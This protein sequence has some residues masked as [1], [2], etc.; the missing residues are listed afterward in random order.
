METI[1]EN[2]DVI[3]YFTTN[4]KMLMEKPY[5]KEDIESAFLGNDKTDGYQNFKKKYPLSKRALPEHGLSVANT[6]EREILESEKKDS[7]GES[8]ASIPFLSK[9]ESDSSSSSSSTGLSSVPGLSQIPG[10]SSAMSNTSG[11]SS[12]TPTLVMGGFSF[13]VMPMPGLTMS[14]I[15]SALQTGQQMSQFVP[16]MPSLPG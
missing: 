13:V 15:G 1:E 5:L 16:G 7:E 9:G 4:D 12:N 14:N 6:A 3:K 10:V 2:T 8:R 11:A